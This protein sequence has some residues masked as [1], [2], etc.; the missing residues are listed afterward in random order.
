MTE[1]TRAVEL[2]LEP[3]G[4]PRTE[5]FVLSGQ[6]PAVIGRAQDCAV[7]LPDVAVSRRHASLTV[8]GGRWL[9]TDLDSRHGT[10]LNGIRLQSQT[11]AIAAAGDLIRV[12]C[13]TLRLA[14]GGVETGAFATTDD[15]ASPGTI[16]ERVPRRELDSLAHRRL[17]LLI[18]GAAVIHQAADE[19]SLARAVLE[20]TIAG[21]GFA[22]AAI[23]RHTGSSD[24]VE[25]LI[26]R[27]VKTS[28]SGSFSFSRSLLREA[29]C[30][31][32]ARLSQTSG[33][34]YGQSID[35]LGITCAVAAPIVL[36]ASVVGYI[37]VDSRELERPGDVDAAG[38]CHAV[39]RLAGLALSS[40]KRAALECR[41]K[42]LDADLKAAQLA[43][44]FLCPKEAGAVG[45]LFYA[46]Q[47]C[48]GRVV[49]GDL[50]D[51]F[52]IDEQRVAVCCG[53]VTGQGMGA[54]ILMTAVL[55]HLR[56]ALA[57][58]GEPAQAVN[59]VNR[60]IS[61]RS[62][63]HMF[64]SLWAGVLDQGEGVLHYV[65]AGHGHWLLRRHDKPPTPAP[66]PNGLLIGIDLDH[67]YSA[68][69]LELEKGDRV[70]LYSD[71]IVEHRN[72]SGEDFGHQRLLEAIAKSDSAERDV[73]DALAAL[74]AF[75]GDAGLADDT[76][77]ASIEFRGKS[78]SAGE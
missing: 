70:V 59:D 30:G 39:A 33:Q 64:A 58:Y 18:D 67:H 74:R 13:H 45:A 11:P 42:Q 76:T 60:Y 5:P 36:D 40:L 63:S 47:T 69:S 37:Y 31:H 32:V 35:Q 56:A 20:L 1:V 49:A 2:R 16:V 15:S 71:G 54:A 28:G 34:D 3:I 46:A 23:L 72:L 22:R 66:R 24:R 38:F 10:F 65:D 68:E 57:R 26:S 29:A 75:I 61:Q 27:D 25:V 17:D 19:E 6:G 44:S 43:Q 14:A 9:L 4:G 41:Q 8:S 52:Q 21:T 12:G 55:S 78:D 50:F 7:C 73:A 51:I 62:P 53:D 48:P 77:I